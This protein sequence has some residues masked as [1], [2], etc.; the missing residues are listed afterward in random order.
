MRFL[1]K[2]LTIHLFVCLMSVQG[3]EA[4]PSKA[5]SLPSIVVAPS[6]SRLTMAEA[7]LIVGELSHENGAFRG[8]YAIKIT[9]F[10]FKNE[11]GRLDLKITKADALKL[12]QGQAVE[13]SGTAT[14][15]KR[16]KEQGV[17]GK[18]EPT[19]ATGGNVSFVVTTSD[20]QIVFNTTYKLIV[21]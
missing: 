20:R 8:D 21:H 10:A 13:F 12:S 4:P 5:A 14:S 3:E 16:N 7:S 18:T 6:K 19:G 11:E 15:N 2:L 1:V 9:P 17:K